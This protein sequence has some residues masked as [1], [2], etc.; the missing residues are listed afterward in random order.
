VVAPA[1]AKR[2]D[3]RLAELRSLIVGELR[4]EDVANVL[5]EAVRLRGDG[6]LRGALQP[7]VEEALER[8]VQSHPRML[9]EALFPI[10]GKAIRRAITA[11]LDGMLQALT[12]TLE[13]SVSV[14]SLKWRWEAIR[15]RRS[16]TEI[17]LLRSLLYRV[18]QVFLIHRHTGLLLI[19]AVAGTT[20]IRDP[21]MVSGMLTAIQDFVRDSIGGAEGENL[22]TI[23]MGDV[24]V[25]LAYGPQAIL[26]G[27]V[28]G[29]AP[30]T[31][32]RTFQDTVDTIEEDKAEELQS[33]AGDPS[34]F[35]SCR[36]QVEAC[37]LG[38]AEPGRE[39]TK[40]G[41]ARVLLFGV[42][43]L[44]IAALLGWWGYSMYWQNRWTGFARRVA[45][46]PGFVV[47]TA[48]KRDGGFLISG[49][50]DPLAVDPATFAQAAGLPLNKIT[51]RW[52]QFHSL[53]PRFASQREYADLKDQLEKHAFRFK[54]AS[55][56]VPP[57]QRFLL[58]DVAAQILALI[59]TGTALGKN[60]RV[61]VIGNHD[62]VGT[63]DVNATLSR[64]RAQSVRDALVLIG[65][66]AARLTT[67]SLDKE[68][69]SAV[70]EEERLLCRSASFR[71]LE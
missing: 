53:D 33:F 30:R 32:N 66:P 39:K 42:P 60:V 59:R 41:I 50:R 7:I 22:E 71:V 63:A 36:P 44:I 47:T 13:Q 57:E 2:S 3:P 49:L 69:C 48:E 68:S 45:A 5:A 37:L 40:S 52:E 26:S 62:P 43:A 35:E 51:F 38:G 67:L 56:E 11:E 15:T 1:A 23:R 64:D 46:E 31:L 61:E 20:E 58:D 28:R 34:T 24:G 29:V 65:V 17:V 9:A 25:V 19:H 8:S 12:Q 55:A 54:T 21:E 16:Y 18:E 10:F 14:R 27:F 4:A 6:K 70:K